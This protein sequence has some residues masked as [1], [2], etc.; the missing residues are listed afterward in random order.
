MAI[1]IGIGLFQTTFEEEQEE[2]YKTNV[3]NINLNK[4]P[5]NNEELIYENEYVSSSDK[6][7]NYVNK[8]KRL[9]QYSYGESLD[10]EFPLEQVG[11]ICCVRSEDSP[12]MCVTEF[13]ELVRKFN[14]TE[15]VSNSTKEYDL[16]GE[17]IN[18][19]DDYF[20][21][22][23]VHMG[24]EVINLLLGSYDFLGDYY[25]I[26]ITKIEK[27]DFT[28]KEVSYYNYNTLAT[29]FNS[30]ISEITFYKNNENKISYF[31]YFIKD[32][33]GEVSYNRYLLL[34]K[35]DYFVSIIYSGATKEFEEEVNFI[36]NSFE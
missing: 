8:L 18:L 15:E 24:G 4:I 16:D 28:H 29:I 14:D 2:I 26:R 19:P 9:E 1:I 36:A 30:T 5:K 11:R 32:D 6:E 23:D 27:I 21:V 22:K 25:E 33:L 13:E 3:Q 10:C 31:D 35:D 20:I 34:E 12:S 17:Y 7:D